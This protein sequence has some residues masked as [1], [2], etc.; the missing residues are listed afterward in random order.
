MV[1]MTPRKRSVGDEQRQGDLAEQRPGAG[2]VDARR[3][4]ERLGNAL[5]AGDEDERRVAEVLPDGEQDD[6][7]HRPA[8]VAQPVD[9]RRCRRSARAAVDEAEARVVEVA[10]DDRHRDERRHVRREE[11]RAEE[12]L[13]SA[14]ASSS[15]AARRRAPTPRVSG[16]PTKRKSAVLR[17]AFQKSGS[18]R[19]RVVLQ[20]DEA[21]VVRSR[22]GRRCRSRS[23]RAGTRR[24]SARGRGRGSPTRPGARSSSGR[25][26]LV[27]QAAGASAVG[28]AARRRSSVRGA[29]EDPAPLLE[30]AVDVRVERGEG[31]RHRPPPAD[32][33]LR[34]FGDLLRDLLPLG[35][36]RHRLDPRELDAEGP[37]LRVSGERGTSQAARRAGRSPGELVE[38]RLTAPARRGTRRS[39][40]RVL[41]LRGRGRSPGSSRRRARR[42]ASAH[43]VRRAAAA[44]SSRAPALGRQAAA[45][46]AEVPRAGD[47]HREVGRARTPGRGCRAA[48]S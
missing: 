3:L 20:A 43:A 19:R 22:R 45:E 33:R 47:P 1:V 10:A 40:G 25:A 8:R 35:H 18:R 21:G 41:L 15:P 46:L 2:A 5:E 13:G 32:R 26:G 17:I 48:C 42:P 23:A 4:V 36:P 34:D 37:R 11:D 9:R 12:A 27:R 24:R 44:P 29:G 39:P 38:A 14:R 31:R 6:R 7:R 30:H 16:P 28:A